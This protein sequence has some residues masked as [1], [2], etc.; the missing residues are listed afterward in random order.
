M[1]AGEHG[2]KSEVVEWV[3]YHTATDVQALVKRLSVDLA[4]ATVGVVHRILAGV[5]KAAVRDRR[6]VSSPCVGT[7]LPT[8][9]RKRL[10]P[11]TVEAVQRLERPPVGAVTPSGVADRYG[12]ARGSRSRRC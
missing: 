4:P 12:Q 3:P 9:H 5:F 2:V 6:T 7:R 10:E 8:I 1:P 11:L